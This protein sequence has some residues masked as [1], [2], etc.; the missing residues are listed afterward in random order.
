VA[1]A[2]PASSLKCVFTHNCEEARTSRFIF[3]AQPMT[4]GPEDTAAAIVEK[5]CSRTERPAGVLSS[6]KDENAHQV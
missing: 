6:R 2:A 1:G 3:Q 4:A 5:N